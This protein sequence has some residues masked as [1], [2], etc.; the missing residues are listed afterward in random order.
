MRP[1]KY[2]LLSLRHVEQ[3]SVG[4]NYYISLA[5]YQVEALIS[6]VSE[7]DT[8]V[9]RHDLALHHVGSNLLLFG[10]DVNR[11]LRRIFKEVTV[12]DYETASVDRKTPAKKAHSIC[13]RIRTKHFTLSFTV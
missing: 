7:V 3:F 6:D 13:C 12:S 9:G 5:E 2:H 1:I 4:Y 11:L 8:R 10:G